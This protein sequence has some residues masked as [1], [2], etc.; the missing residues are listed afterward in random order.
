M[1][2]LLRVFFVYLASGVALAQDG[3]PATSRL[4]YDVR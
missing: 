4:N 3:V 2:H 1:Q